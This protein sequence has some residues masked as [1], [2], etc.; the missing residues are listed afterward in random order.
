MK[1]EDRMGG[2]IIQ[3]MIWRCLEYNECVLYIM[4]VIFI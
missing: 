2:E 3:E 4:E 1:V